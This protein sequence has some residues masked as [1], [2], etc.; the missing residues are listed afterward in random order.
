MFRILLYPFSLLYGLVV[1]IRN[2]LFDCKILKSIQFNIPVISV[3]N[4]TVGG[5]GK[6]PHVEYLI[7]LLK[8]KRNIAVL[9]RGYKRKT[10]GFQIADNQST[11]AD[12]GDEPK[13][14]KQKFSKITVAVDANRVNGLNR[15]IKKGVD[16]VILDDAFQHR[17]VKPG[18]SILLI[19]YNRDINKDYL[20]PYGRLRESIKAKDRA[21]IIIVSKT[22]EELK[23]I[24]RRLIKK[25]LKPRPYQE[26]YFTGLKYEKLIPVLSDTVSMPMDWGLST[27][28]YS[29][30]LVTGIARAGQLV[31][32][33]KK[34][35]NN[36]HHLNY[37]DHANYTSKRIN[38][39]INTFNN[40]KNNKKIIITTEK[41]AVKIRELKITDMILK[42]NMFYLPVE[43][44]FISEEQEF[45]NQIIRYVGENK[46]NS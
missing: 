11:C 43:V 24:D 4:I 41:D 5:T 8:E 38:K 2:I 29:V 12:I 33:I 6:T 26:L 31:S 20:L 25:N 23:P 36:V 39:I 21:D 42:Q 34:F 45:R 9:S 35:S 1:G 32:H 7:N 18:L 44:Y 28:I 30:V 17:Y 13:Q 3:G 27:N 22:P 15:L 10:K 16:T 19:D 14:M 46:R 40:I 37:S